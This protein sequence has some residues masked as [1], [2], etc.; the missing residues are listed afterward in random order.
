[1]FDEASSFR[2][3]SLD[4]F[5]HLQVEDLFQFGDLHD[6]HML[7][8]DE[9]FEVNRGEGPF[10]R[11]GKEVQEIPIIAPVFISPDMFEEE[12]GPLKSLSDFEMIITDRFIMRD[13]LW[14]DPG[15]FQEF[16]RV[17]QFSVEAEV[18]GILEIAVLI[19][20][21]LPR[22]MAIMIDMFE[23]V[24]TLPEADVVDDQFQL[25]FTAFRIASRVLNSRLICSSIMIS[26]TPMSSYW[27]AFLTVLT[28]AVVETFTFRRGKRFLTRSMR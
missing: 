28:R 24:G 27:R 11:K 17:R 5:P 3:S 16:H 2:L 7:G 1:M 19:L 14:P 9:I 26:S 18:A 6:V 25:H 22:G 8:L 21:S 12:R 13:I 23:V 15:G 10:P 20:F 4:Q